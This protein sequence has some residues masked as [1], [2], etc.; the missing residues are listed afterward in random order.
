MIRQMKMTSG[1]MLFMSASAL[2]L[3][4]TYAFAVAAHHSAAQFDFTKPVTV[5]GIVK[6]FVV[7]NPHTRAIVT[8][9]DAT[10]GTRDIEYEGHS[11]S[12][13]YRG[14]YTRELVKNGDEIEISFAPRKDGA[15]G[16]YLLSFTIHGKTVLLRGAPSGSGKPEQSK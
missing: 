13:F 5:K 6:E 1:S 3:S 4:L 8:V 10:K 11:A 15:D 12:H 9:T 16:G 7:V 14:G 2:A